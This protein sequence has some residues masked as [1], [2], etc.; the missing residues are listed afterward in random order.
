MKIL[1]LDLLAFGP[2]TDTSL[3]FSAPGLHVVY[4]PNE[5]GKS[6]ALRSITDVLYGIPVRTVDAH[7]HDHARLRIGAVVETGGQTLDVVRK[8]GRTKTLLD[9]QGKPVDEAPL[10]AALSRV[11]RELYRRMFGLDHRSLREGARAMLEGK[12]ELAETL[13]DAG[14]GG[15]TRRVLARLRDEAD[16]LFKPRGKN[17]TLAQTLREIDRLRGEIEQQAT[18]PSAM[19][20]QREGL[21]AAQ[22]ERARLE[23]ERVA[24]VSEL[25][26]LER[27]QRVWPR[28]NRRRELVVARAALGPVP[29]LPADA[30][31]RRVAFV[32]QRE[33]ARQERRRLEAERE[34]L[35]AERAALDGGDVG[36]ELSAAVIEEIEDALGRHRSA[37]QDRPKRKGELG[38]IERD[39]VRLQRE[40]GREPR[41]F[42]DL[43]ALR[44]DKPT[45]RRITSLAREHEALTRELARAREAVGAG[46][47]DEEEDAP[48]R[49]QP[50]TRTRLEAGLR[51]AR[52][53]GDL[54]ARIATLEAQRRARMQ[55][56]EAMAEALGVDADTAVSWRVPTATWLEA[57][58]QRGQALDRAQDEDERE[59]AALE[60]EEARL[61]RAR[62]DLANG[63][64]PPTAEQLE[65]ARERRDEV[66]RGWSRERLVTGE[67]RERLA[68]LVAEADHVVDRMR[69]EAERVASFSR[70]AAEEARLACARQT[71]VAR[72][73]R[74]EAARAALHE[75]IVATWPEGAPALVTRTPSAW[76]SWFE[77]H[78]ALLELHGQAA[79]LREELDTLATTRREAVMALA[80]ALD[81]AADEAVGGAADRVADGAVALRTWIERATVRLEAGD[82]AARHVEEAARRRRDARARAAE[83]EETEVRWTAWERQ[84][85][86]VMASIGMPGATEIET[87]LEELDVRRGWLEQARVARDLAGRLEGMARDETAFATRMAELVAA[88]RP[89]LAGQPPAAAAEAL[90]AAARATR[91]TQ[92]RREDL[93]ARADKLTAQRVAVDQRR[94]EADT[95]LHALTRLA[96]VDD[97]E[98]LA[99]VERRAREH[100]A[101]TQRIDE[102]NDALYAEG[103]I[104]EL[105]RLV[106]GFE[107]DAAR[108]QIAARREALDELEERRARL[109]R[110]IGSKETGLE[111]SVAR[112]GA[113][114]AQS[115]LEG[116]LAEFRR[117]AERWAKLR[118]AAHILSREV[119]AYRQRNQGPLVARAGAIFPRLTLGEYR[120]LE[121]AYDENDTPTLH[122]IGQNG[123]AV[124]VDG[125]S[126]GARDQLFLSLRLASLERY[127]EQAPLLPIVADDILIHFDED[128]TR[129]SLET[130]EAMTAHGQVLLFTHQARHVELA[131][132]H[133]ESLTVHRLGG[134]HRRADPSA[135]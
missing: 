108:L 129:A 118:L 76:L 36:V 29:R 28:L 22:A 44:V 55:E 130:L 18:T 84:W 33:V 122:C 121:V 21:V 70:L 102:E 68:R 85:C 5:A 132:A 78:R 107:P 72:A 106:A 81:A 66:L 65:A 87:A 135:S 46:P 31:E 98:A 80:T 74:R 23:T 37:L 16:A 103:A 7:R 20:T 17:Q 104:E 67:A 105:E 101:L 125:L 3:D 114:R 91:E 71:L 41:S 59:A 26:R 51:A 120:G 79:R 42:D 99:E 45:A 131:E 50:E 12:G 116:Q 75:E 1:R 134:G 57:W 38:R 35:A 19:T 15:Q 124:E 32:Q 126:D 110:D 94:D 34:E 123:S 43:E 90:L 9:R 113:A 128:R 64:E 48:A 25:G 69:H 111:R 54:D 82:V 77:R 52:A 97:A 11:P 133:L 62:A 47:P 73:E 109:D 10:R 92:R 127:A 4:G 63:D 56:L 13:F 88:H 112:V 53:E 119:E 8:K 27:A 89:A 6:T 14:G 30:A 40:H 60:T 83:L 39:L 86:E 115:E 2:F 100:E 24:V 95:A 58:Q 49:L 96:G 61:T 117:H 93:A